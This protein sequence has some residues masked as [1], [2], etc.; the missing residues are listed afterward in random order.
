MSRNISVVTLVY[1][2]KPEEMGR[3]LAG[4]GATFTLPKHG[5]HIIRLGTDGSLAN[6]MCLT[7]RLEMEETSC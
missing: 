6:I 1:S 7:E 2:K 5:S 3:G 4:G